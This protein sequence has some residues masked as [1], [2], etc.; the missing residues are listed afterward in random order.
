MFQPNPR[1]VPFNNLKP[2]H[3][4]IATMRDKQASYS[5]IAE[6]L[7]QHGVKT[8]RARVAEYGRI[9]LDGGKRHKR[10]KYSH[11]TPVGTLSASPPVVLADASNVVPFNEPTKVSDFLPLPSSAPSSKRRGPRIAHV[12]LMSPQEREKFEDDIKTKQNS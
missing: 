10:R 3:D 12:E 5:L 7:Q 2:H 8:S 9:V 6:L 1:R 4:A 11:L